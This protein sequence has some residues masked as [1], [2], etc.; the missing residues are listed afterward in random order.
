MCPLGN[1]DR[2]GSG[3]VVAFFAH[4]EAGLLQRFRT[5]ERQA[6]EAVYRAYVDSVARA[7]SG[8]LRRYCGEALLGGW[9]GVA[10]ELP[11][12]VQEVFTRAFEPDARLRF[13]GVRDFA[14]YLAWDVRRDNERA[15]ERASAEANDRYKLDTRLSAG[16]LISG[17]LCAAAALVM[18]SDSP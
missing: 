16:F 6:L 8:A 9:R 14:P 11:D 4:G 13:D 12:L 17:A 5:G 15:V 18:S 3:I 7:V 2:W 10:G 1:G